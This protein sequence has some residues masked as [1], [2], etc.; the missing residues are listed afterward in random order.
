[1]ELKAVL[2]MFWRRL[3]L[4][5]VTAAAALAVAVAGTLYATPIYGASATLR[6]A[7]SVGG[8]SSWLDAY[9]LINTYTRMATSR[10][11]LDG[12]VTK[13]GL[14][15]P[16]SI[17]VQ[18]IADTELIKITVEDPSPSVARDAANTLAEMLVA[19]SQEMYSGGAKSASSILGEQMAQVEN[20]LRQAQEEYGRLLAATPQDPSAIDALKQS[21]DMK[22]GIYGTLVQQYE[23]ARTTEEMQANALSIIEPAVT[24]QFPSKPKKMQ[25]LVLGSLVGLMGGLALAILFEQLDTSLRTVRQIQE[26]TALSALGVLPSVRRGHTTLNLSGNSRQP[27][28]YRRLRINIYALARKG[29]LKTLMVT[30]AEPGE[31]KSTIVSNLARVMAQSGRRVVA[32]DGDLRRPALHG[33]FKMQNGSGLSNILMK[34]ATV[35]EA[36]Q[37]DTDA[38]VWVLTSGTLPKDP[39]V[40]LE[41]AQ[42]GDLLETL[43]ERF[44]HVLLDSPALLAVSDAVVLA[45]MVDGIVLVVNSVQAERENLRSACQQLTDVK[46]NLVGVVVNRMRSDG[47]ARYQAYYQKSSNS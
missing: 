40:V 2:S 26:V 7:V 1:M 12:L 19:K 32:V 16:P 8:T 5:A 4:I 47:S 13:L 9:R 39:A 42:M 46:G 44:D 35:E 25:N 15:E 11:V 34:S 37:Y 10:P 43:A 21:I 30:S 45:P 29:N 3:W 20:E 24:P 23:R 22:Q 36:L 17:V 14:S 33:A 41:S 28:A 31:G 6:V 27:E 38:Q 18:A